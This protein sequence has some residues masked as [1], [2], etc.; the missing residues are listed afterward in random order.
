MSEH[1]KHC[2]IN[3]EA[4]CCTCGAENADLRARLDAALAAVKTAQEA[5]R[6]CGGYIAWPEGYPDTVEVMKAN[7]KALAAIDAV[8]GGRP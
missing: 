4:E 7:L 5:L 3:G 2:A 8:L 6:L 1:H